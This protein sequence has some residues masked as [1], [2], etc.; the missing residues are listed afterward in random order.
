[1]NTTESAQKQLFLRKCKSM[2]NVFLDDMSKPFFSAK[3]KQSISDIVVRL[4]VL[5][6]QN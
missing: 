1:M 3:E 2:R 5:I 6:V 4:D